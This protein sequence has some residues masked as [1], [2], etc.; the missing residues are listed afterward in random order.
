[1]NFF[2]F[3]FSTRINEDLSLFGDDLILSAGV[4]LCAER[5]RMG[6]V[7][8]DIRQHRWSGEGTGATQE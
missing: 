7:H 6:E 4:Q 3:I 5:T 8:S 2:S 1:M